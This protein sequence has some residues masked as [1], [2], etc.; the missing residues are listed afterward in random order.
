VGYTKTNWTAVSLFED[1]ATKIDVRE[2]FRLKKYEVTMKEVAKV[3][4]GTHCKYNINYHFVWIPKTRMKILV[5][6][7]KTEVAGLIDVISK[8]NH[9]HPLALE[10]MPDHLHYFVSAH[11]KW[12]PMKMVQLLKQESS[13][14]LRRKYSS[15]R[16]TRYSQDF[17]ATGY[18]CGT[19][20]HVSAAQVARY[21]L[22]QTE[23]L[24]NKWNLFDLKPFEYD[25]HEGVVPDKHQKRL[26]AFG[27]GGFDSD[28]RTA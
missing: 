26:N 15:L 7:F 6:P 1:R 24:K 16:N 12:A 13:K 17:W 20:G 5:E 3:R 27:I 14:K 8:R 10:I 11:P 18:Y 4:Y 9:W 21:I 22:E 2:H 25:I 23:K 19:A 28:L